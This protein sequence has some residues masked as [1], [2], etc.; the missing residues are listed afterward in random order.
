MKKYLRFVFFVVILAPVTVIAQQLK[1]SE[2]VRF[3]GVVT[4]Q[5]LQTAEKPVH[6]AAARAMAR[7]EK[8]GTFKN[9]RYEL[10]PNVRMLTPAQKSSI[11]L[12]QDGI[13]DLSGG[14]FRPS[15]DSVYLDPAS[16]LV[17]QAE[18]VDESR[19]LALRPS[20][21]AVFDDIEV[22]EQ[23]VPLTLANTVS[24]AQGVVESSLQLNN[25][26]AVNLQF[27]SV[28]F[29]ID[30][31]DN[32]S[33]VVT[34]VGQIQ[35][36]NPRVE[37]KYTK[38][39]GYR[40]VF[41]ASEQ[42]DMKIY[43]SMKLKEEAKTPVWGTEIELS[44]LGKCEIGLFIL[45][46]LEGHVT[47]AVEIHQGI[48][49]AM[50]ASGGTFWYIP[51]SIKNI[52]TIDSW[53]E[54]GYNI[55]SE[56]KAFAGFQC[57]ANLKVK[58]YNA[59]DVYVNGGMEGTVATDGMTLSADVGLRLKAGG[60]IVSKKFTLLDNYYS[61]WK[62]QKPDY[63]GYSMVIHEA[64]AWGDYVAGEIHNLVPGKVAGVMDTVPYEGNLT[65]MVDHGVNA[66]NE[67]S[68]STGSDG[69][70]IARNV[71]LRKGDRVAVRLQGV[72]N[73][74]PAVD[75]TIPFREIKLYSADYFTGVA[76]GS[77]AG[78]RSRWA[79]LA[80]AQ[81]GSV[82]AAA[83]AIGGAAAAERLRGAI[84][85]QEAAKRVNEFRNNLTVY[86]GP[87]E[88]ITATEP[89]AT[90]TAV[91]AQVKPSQGSVKTGAPASASAGRAPVPGTSTTTGKTSIPSTA[92]TAAKTAV[93]AT[94]T[95]AG[96]LMSNRGM[97]DSPLGLFSVSGMTFEPGQRVRARIEVEGFI[98]ESDW[99]ETEGL[100][101]SSIGHDGFRSSVRPGSE[102]F[103]AD[104]SFVVVSALHGEAAPQ[105]EVKI[106]RGAGAPHA[107]LTMPQP[108]PE[109]P[110]AG[111]AKI[112]FSKSIP[113]V[114]LEG[115]PGA[116]IASTGPWSVTYGYSSP[117]DAL[118]PL[119]NRKHPFEMVSYV[120]SGTDL[121]YSSHTDEC[122]SCTS[123][124]SVID[125]IGRDD[126]PG[127]PGTGGTR[128]QP[129]VQ[130]E[131]KV[132]QAKPQQQVKKPVVIR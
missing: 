43:T 73:A 87:I 90:L 15:P 50:G 96:K 76:G 62:Y 21:S 59:L 95:A 123:P 99:I 41:L 115:Y 113:L 47:L 11:R 120:F 106:V 30:K 118:N 24:L 110:D 75:V 56:M 124:A 84:P 132:P 79:K 129:S 119:K 25:S 91:P 72:P 20:L 125:R 14:A 7:G 44:D 35:L 88:F 98:V 122:T 65:V 82:P 78:S 92:A 116:A 61:L 46:T 26:Y 49:M 85:Q 53:C 9:V 52:S 63:H 121:G 70:F 5:D 66:R 33:L 57:T 67:Y 36:T 19:M 127:A 27:D 60:K 2:S 101:V 38:N 58:G 97:V 94:A 51:T 100:M 111:K 48:E 104:N 23:E 39:N 109:F 77:V 83:A 69:V 13:L 55:T 80:G 12:Q 71:P 34:L 18:P 102:T 130:R 22:P 117:G 28:S 42:V 68:V 8:P 32:D 126:I 107:S 103:A 81:Q 93:P 31:V 3:D 128:G 6:P 16:D 105:G 108:V 54:V 45:T 74:S 40:L 37:G 17:L 1:I 86:R 112:W 4:V 64:C 29:L 10:A 114:P 89:P 131:V